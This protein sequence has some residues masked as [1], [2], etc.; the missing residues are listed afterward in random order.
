M[1]E[2]YSVPLYK[3][4]V[5]WVLVN[6]RN[7]EFQPGEKLPTEQALS[8]RFDVSRGTVRTALGALCKNRVLEVLHGSGYY[9]S[10][11][12]D[13][14]EETDRANT[15]KRMDRLI[16]ELRQAGISDNEIQ[17]CF[18]LSLAHTEQKE[19]RAKITVI[20]CNPD[21][22]PVYHRQFSQISGAEI[23]YCLIETGNLFNESINRADI[24]VTTHNH[25]K[26]VASLRPDLIDRIIRYNISISRKT[27]LAI[28]ALRGRERIGLVCTSPRYVQMVSEALVSFH[29]P[30][31]SIRTAFPGQLEH[32]LEKIDRL[33][34]PAGSRIQENNAAAIQKYLER[35]GIILDFDYQI[36]KGSIAYIEEQ[37]AMIRNE[38]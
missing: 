23:D 37:V 2:Q 4:I 8:K 20:E 13:V 36:E 38:E 17:Y 28:S 30:A 35:G 9:V 12:Q 5:E 11:T 3:K 15:L 1:A 16:R 10:K 26:E 27:L 31:E 7:G 14:L 25:F 34:L 32:L 29:I 33:I 6:I 19:R 22:L 21:I 24:I 18:R